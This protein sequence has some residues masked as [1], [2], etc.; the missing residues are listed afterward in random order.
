MCTCDNIYEC[1]CIRKYIV[2]LSDFDSIVPYYK[3]RSPCPAH[4]PL[5]ASLDG[6]KVL[7]T[8]EYRAAPEVSGMSVISLPILYFK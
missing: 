3:Q 5:P 7:G 8:P 6:A 2:Q 4:S 1:T